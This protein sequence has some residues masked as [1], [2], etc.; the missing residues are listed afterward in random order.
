MAANVFRA[1]GGAGAIGLLAT[2]AVAGATKDLEQSGVYLDA[3]PSHFSQLE[4]DAREVAREFCAELGGVDEFEPFEQSEE[5]V[6]EN[7]YSTK[8]RC[9]VRGRVACYADE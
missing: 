8:Y 4:H 3:C 7:E 1:L 2:S 5:I 9:T 6:R